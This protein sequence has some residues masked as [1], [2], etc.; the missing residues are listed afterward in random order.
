MENTQ[1]YPKLFR[2]IQ[3][4]LWVIKNLFANYEYQIII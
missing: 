4:I 3:A 2:T 1:K